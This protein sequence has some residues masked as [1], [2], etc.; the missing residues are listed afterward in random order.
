MKLEWSGDFA[1]FDCDKC[2]RQTTIVVKDE[3]LDCYYCAYCG[4]LMTVENK[5]EDSQ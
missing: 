2:Y 1:H 5:G 3:I 4:H